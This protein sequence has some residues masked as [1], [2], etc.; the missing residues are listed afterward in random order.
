MNTMR[1]KNARLAS[2]E[3]SAIQFMVSTHPSREMAWKSDTMAHGKLSKDV[4][5]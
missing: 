1:M 4:M 2:P 5:P 3:T